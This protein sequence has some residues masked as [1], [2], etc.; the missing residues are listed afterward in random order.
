M[1]PL[2]SRARRASSVALALVVA[3]VA[4][5]AP[6]VAEACGSC[7][8]PGGAGSAL[9]APWQTYGF[10][11]AETMRLGQGVF[12]QR[13]RFRPFK[14]DSHDRVI[15]LAFAGAVRPIDSVELGATTAYGN[16]LVSGPG[17]RSSRG[18]LGDL[19]LRA[20]WEILQEPPLEL[21]GQHRLPA[22]G[23]TVTSRLPTGP[24]DRTTSAGAA[25][26]SPGT[27]GS[28]A[29]SQGLGTTELALSVDVRKSFASRFQIGAVG[30]AAWRA[31]D[32][33]IGLRR[34][35]APRGLVRLM[36]IVFQGDATLGL[37]ADLAAEGDVQYGGR[38]SPD[39]GQRSVSLGV[40]ATYKTSLGFRSG[41]A[42]SH[43]PPIDGLSKNAVAATGLTAF[44]AFTR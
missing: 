25:G 28:T 33:S 16:V 42:L 32:E 27:V 38:T 39:S 3:L 13:S 4:F 36:G 44:I 15:E 6:R 30:E 37:F 29:T 18:A 31:P 12:D 8:G 41:L 1:T 17:F 10:S 40:S 35:L 26:P 9:T 11:I 43:Q 24:V 19:S 20:R 23:V 2:E 5:A 7:R 34:A 14:Q 22:L 21:T